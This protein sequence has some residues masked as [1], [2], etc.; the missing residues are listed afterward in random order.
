MMGMEIQQAVLKSRL[1]IYEAVLE[2]LAGNID[3][4]IG[5]LAAAVK[6][7]IAAMQLTGNQNSAA[8]IEETQ[9]MLSELIKGL[10]NI[11]N[12]SYIICLSEMEI[13]SAVEMEIGRF[14]RVAGVRVNFSLN[15]TVYRFAIEKTILLFRTW[16]QVMASLFEEGKCNGLLVAITYQP[17]LVSIRIS[18]DHTI[19]ASFFDG[20]IYERAELVGIKCTVQNKTRTATQNSIILEL[21]TP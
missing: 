9:M 8:D 5:Q 12:N 10:Q 15:G 16:Q 4:H 1:E 6:F 17:Q 2:Q 7:K 11:S 20:D 14:C 3:N 13:I 18:S 21:T 19:N